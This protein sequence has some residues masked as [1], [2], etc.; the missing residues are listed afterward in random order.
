MI[1]PETEM[2]RRLPLFEK[3]NMLTSAA[4]VMAF[5]SSEASGGFAYGLTMRVASWDGGVP[6]GAVFWLVERGFS[7]GG[8]AVA[9]GRDVVAAGGVSVAV[10]TVAPADTCDVVVATA[11]GG[12]DCREY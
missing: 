7:G 12:G 2:G 11:S 4:R 10:V 3:Q 9:F 8:V 6:A 5:T 1:V